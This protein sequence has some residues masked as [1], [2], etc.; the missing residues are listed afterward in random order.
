MVLVGYWP[1]DEESGDTA[2]DV[3]GSN[4]GSLNAGVSYTSAG[5]LNQNCAEF[6]GSSGL[7]DVGGTD[8]HIAGS[9]P[10]SVSVWVKW[11]GTET[12]EQHGIYTQSDQSSNNPPVGLFFNDDG[13]VNFQ[14]SN[15]ASDGTFCSSSTGALVSGKWTNIVGVYSHSEGLIKLYID[16]ELMQT[17]SHNNGIWDVSEDIHFGNWKPQYSD[18]LSASLNEVRIYNHALTK[19]EVHY[20]YQVGSRGL[21]TSDKR[22]L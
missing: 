17:E 2:Y 7:I 20:L 4:N 5:I 1:L 6:D 11:D 8:W 3:R 18:W 19:Q 16:G 13:T 10:I 15:S 22:T 9:N 14:V 21:H 12:G